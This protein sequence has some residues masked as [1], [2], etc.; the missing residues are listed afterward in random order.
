MIKINPNIN[1]KNEFGVSYRKSKNQIYIKDNLSG[2]SLP[3]GEMLF[4]IIENVTILKSAFQGNSNLVIKKAFKYY[5]YNLYSFIKKFELNNIELELLQKIKYYLDLCCINKEYCT[6]SKLENF[7][8]KLFEYKNFTLNLFSDITISKIRKIQINDKNTKIYFS[9]TIDLINYLDSKYSIYSFTTQNS[10]T[11][12]SEL[13]IISLFEI[14]SLHLT[15][16][17]CNS[18]NNYFISVNDDM[19]CNRAFLDNDYLGCYELEQ[20]AK[21][22][23]TILKKKMLI[24]Q[25]LYKRA[26][27]NRIEKINIFEEF[28]TGWKAVS[29]KS[30]EEKIKFL[31]LDD[32]K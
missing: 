23:N 19:L 31:N 3:V 16:K 28:K 7:A 30:N 8:I 4:G 14:F 32:W 29:N 22:D 27:T 24:Y 15:I 2:F 10:F 11:S 17:K 9:H 13:C 20:R 6:L 21:D 5:K 18:C 26:L 25:R 1:L 12:L